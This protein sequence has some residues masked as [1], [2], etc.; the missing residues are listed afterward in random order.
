[1]T[2]AVMMHPIS[3][4]I[5]IATRLATKIE[6]PNCW[7]WTAPTNAVWESGAVGSYAPRLHLAEHLEHERDES[8]IP[9]CD[10]SGVERKVTD[11]RSAQL[12]QRAR[13]F[14]QSALAQPVAGELQHHAVRLAVSHGQR[15]IGYGER[16][17]H[18]ELASPSDFAACTGAQSS[19]RRTPRR[20]GPTPRRGT[21]ANPARRHPSSPPLRGRR[22]L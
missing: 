9:C 3:R 6:A 11:P 1:M 18:V 22:V 8:R 10:L 2:M 15:R 5:A 4:V 20:H 7:S 19:G 12:T 17:V 14:W 21:T 13:R 16:T